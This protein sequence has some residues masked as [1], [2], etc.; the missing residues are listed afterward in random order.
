MCT[1]PLDFHLKTCFN[2][3]HGKWQSSLPLFG[4]MLAQQKSVIYLYWEGELALLLGWR[5]QLGVVP[6]PGAQEGS[7]A[8]P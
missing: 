6:T 5:G 3:C 8:G 7:R 4:K 2:Y 1:L